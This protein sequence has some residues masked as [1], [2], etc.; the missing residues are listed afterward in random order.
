[1]GVGEAFMGEACFDEAD[2]G[3]RPRLALEVGGFMGDIGRPEPPPVVV[4]LREFNVD[5]SLSSI[6]L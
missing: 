3:G 6:A 1:M 5:C 2:G 4:P